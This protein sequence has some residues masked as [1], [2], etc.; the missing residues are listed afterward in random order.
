MSRVARLAAEYTGVRPRLVGIAYSIVGTLAEAQDVVSDCWLKLVEADGRD[1]V[2]DV[3][4]WAVVAVAR[5]AVD[6]LRSAR[7][8]RERYVGPWLPEP[9]VDTRSPDPAERVT[10][11]DS[12]GFALMVV[13]ETLT[14]AERTTWV[15]H[16]VFGMPF[17]EIAEVVGRSPA[18]VRQ[19]AVRARAH[20]TARAPRV[21]VA[22]PEHRRVVDAFLGAVRGGDLA[23]LLGLLDPDVVLTSDGGGLLGV[24]RRPVL[25]ADRVGRF[26]VGVVRKIAAGEHLRPLTVNGG[27]GFAVLRADGS[28]RYVCSFTPVGGLVRRVDFVVAPDKLPRAVG[29]YPPGVTRPDS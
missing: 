8:R 22:G 1:P 15:L 26:L 23:A 12:V 4:G 28:T 6:V 24:A 7:V 11:D 17:P 25:G 20:V 10:L 29:P 16:E 2:L 9:L 21:D 27:P 18:A 14:P 13:L 19:L 5:R 3:E